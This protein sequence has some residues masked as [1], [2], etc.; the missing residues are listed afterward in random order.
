MRDVY[1][2]RPVAP[3]E[4]PS[5]MR[6]HIYTGAMAMICYT[7]VGGMFFVDYGNRV[8]LSYW[9]WGLLNSVVTMAVL[10][11]LVGA[12]LAGLTG[13]RKKLWFRTAFVARLTRGVGIGLSFCLFPRSPPAAVASLIA[14]TS[15]AAVFEAL[16][17][18]PWQSWLT[19][20]IPRGLHGT[21]VGRRHAWLSSAGVLALVPCGI[22]LDRMHG[23]ARL[24][25]LVVVFAAGLLL[26]FIDIFIH[27]TIPEPESVRATTR[28]FLRQASAVLRDRLFRPLIVFRACWTFSAMLG[29]SLAMIYFVKDL[30]FT[31]KVFMGVLILQVVPSL[32]GALLAPRTGKL[33]DRVGARTVLF[34][35]YGVLSVLPVCWILATAETAS[36]WLAPAALVGGA[37]GTAGYIALDKVVLRV[38][39]RSERAM[40]VAVSNCVTGLVAAAAP[41]IA[42]FVLEALKD[43]KIFVLGREVVGFHLIFSASILLSLFSMLL[44]RNIPE[45]KPYSDEFAPSDRAA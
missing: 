24:G 18:P 29:G 11:Q 42:G 43:W 6:K 37:A 13:Q 5:L 38:P 17:L 22:F 41:L 35:A 20:I 33:V 4:L 19:A 7:L 23:E 32:S 10:F 2:H 27:R 30:G 16:S 21:F 34:G 28:S 9:H 44:A 3:G 14:F 39:A 15:L 45:P 36:Y 12:R 40:Y 8:G 25:T 26:G 1:A 31:H